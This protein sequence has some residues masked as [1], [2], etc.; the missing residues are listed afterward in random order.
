M[1][2]VCDVCN[3]EFATPA[4]LGSHKR[5]HR[6]LGAETDSKEPITIR[7]LV[8]QTPVNSGVQPRPYECLHCGG[9]LSLAEDG[10]GNYHLRCTRCWKGDE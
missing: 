6:E 4:A 7:V 10:I 8:E 3:L 2:N 1:S 9:E 5:K